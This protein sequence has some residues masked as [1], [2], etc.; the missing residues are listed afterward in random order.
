MRFMQIGPNEVS[1]AATLAPY[2]QLACLLLTL[3]LLP[4]FQIHNTK[5]HVY[6]FEFHPRVYLHTIRPSDKHALR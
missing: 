6:H 4:L 1:H 3:G 2:E 5:I